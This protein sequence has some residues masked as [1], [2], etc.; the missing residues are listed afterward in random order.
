M[1]SSE[2]ADRCCIRTPVVVAFELLQASQQVVLLGC[3][4][5]SSSTST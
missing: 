3:Q 2:D 5:Q 1:L 4:G